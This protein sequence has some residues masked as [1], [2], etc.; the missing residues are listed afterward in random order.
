VNRSLA[1]PTSA[2]L[3][4]VRIFRR[5]SKKTITAADGPTFGHLAC[6][7]TPLTADSSPK[8]CSKRAES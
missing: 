6:I 1:G 2:A 8:G 4:N 3:R 5:S 7:R